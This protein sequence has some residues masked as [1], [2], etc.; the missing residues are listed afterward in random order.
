MLPRHCSAGV[1][2]L[3]A[4]LCMGPGFGAN[5]PPPPA[6][7]QAATRA[8]PV[9]LP[10]F[11]PG[12]W[13]YRRT[14]QTSQ[15]GAPQVTVIKRCVDPTSEIKQKMGQL[16]QKGCVFS[17]LTKDGDRYKTSGTCQGTGA[18]VSIQQLLTASNADSYKDESQTRRGDFTNR[19]T[20]L[21]RRLGECPAPAPG[22]GGGPK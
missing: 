17:G 12:W 22:P 19:S 15:R 13:E 14:L 7:A 11:H 6:G 3:V 16:K 20:I 9:Q 18:K 4:L 8:A 5:P 1:L 2:G 21:A 10:A